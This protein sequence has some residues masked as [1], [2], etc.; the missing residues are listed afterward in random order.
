MVNSVKEAT[1]KAHSFLLVPLVL[2]GLGVGAVAPEPPRAD[3]Y[4]CIATFVPDTILRGAEAVTVTY[5]LTE[6]IGAI[7]KVVADE[8]SG[9][10][11]A[12]VDPTSTTVTLNTQA[13]SV[14]EW[15]LEVRGESETTCYGLVNVQGLEN[16]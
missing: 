1:M 14:G 10:T 9:I 15:G 7:Q 11:V 2:A 13:A 16:R 6:E 3:P 5:G 12:G 8:A 4:D